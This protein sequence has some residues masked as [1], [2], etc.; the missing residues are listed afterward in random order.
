LL[1][2]GVVEELIPGQVYS[3]PV[4]T[5]VFQELMLEELKNFYATGLKARRPNSMNN[6]GVIVNEI[7][8][9]PLVF[10]MQERIIK[11]LAFALFPEEGSHLQSHHSFTIR[12]KGGEDTHLDVHTDDSDVTF[13]VNIGG[14]YTGCPLVFCGLSGEPDHR[15][16]KLAHQHRPGAAVLHRGQHRHGAEDIEAGERTNLVVWSYSRAFRS[17]TAYKRQHLK[18]VGPPHPRCLSYTHDRD[19]GQFKQY[20]AGKRERFEGRGWCPQK[21]AEYDGFRADP[22]AIRQA[23]QS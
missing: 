15:Q 4:F 17:T 11:P 21:Q 5:P 19:F 8:M 18:E 13:N 22:P 9:E 6:Y 20:P 14:N 3:F 16:F 23:P 2:A 7:G 1:G 10:A 12:Y